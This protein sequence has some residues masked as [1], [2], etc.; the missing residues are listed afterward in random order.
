MAFREVLAKICLK[1]AKISLAS[2]A[3][4][5]CT[6]DIFA[7]FYVCP[8]GVNLIGTPLPKS[9]YYGPLEPI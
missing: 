2:L 9:M 4:Q 3:I 7:F 5:K 8:R 6:L 1:I